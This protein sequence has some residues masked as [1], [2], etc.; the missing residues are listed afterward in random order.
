MCAKVE[1]S[2]NS[3][4]VSVRALPLLKYDSQP[5]ANEH[6]L[7]LPLSAAIGHGV[8]YF[9]IVLPASAATW[10]PAASSLSASLH[11]R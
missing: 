5:S 2:T 1:I 4:R 9:P 6:S 3:N 8:S 7:Q 11:P 10:Q